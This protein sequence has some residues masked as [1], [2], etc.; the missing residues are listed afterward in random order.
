MFRFLTSDCHGGRG[1]HSK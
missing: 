1:I